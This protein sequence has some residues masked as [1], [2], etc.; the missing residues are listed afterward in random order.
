MSRALGKP[1]LD[2]FCMFVDRDDDTDAGVIMMHTQ[3]KLLLKKSVHLETIIDDNR[4]YYRWPEPVCR[5]FLETVF[6]YLALQTA[7]N[8]YFVTLRPAIALFHVT[9]KSHMLLHCAIYSFGISPSMVWNYMGEDFMGR[10]KSLVLQNTAGTAWLKVNEKLVDQY[11]RGMNSFLV[12]D[13]F[14]TFRS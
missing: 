6:E 10:I 2:V 14:D 8:T 12:D 11:C 1:L 9:I 3:I 13:T 5:E 4:S 7:L